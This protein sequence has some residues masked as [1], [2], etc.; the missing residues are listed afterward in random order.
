MF[1]VSRCAQVKLSRN[2]KS[3]DFSSSFNSFVTHLFYLTHVLLLGATGIRW[4]AVVEGC[5]VYGGW[6]APR[7]RWWCLGYR[8]V[9]V[10]VVVVGWWWC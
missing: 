3:A 6:V 7:R 4:M 9:V 8:V 2:G 5:Q 1:R 10:V